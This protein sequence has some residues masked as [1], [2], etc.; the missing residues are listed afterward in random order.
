MARRRRSGLGSLGTFGISLGIGFAAVLVGAILP[1]PDG[2]IDKNV[3]ELTV[4]GEHLFVAQT[5]GTVKV[6]DA[7][8]GDHLY[9]ISGLDDIGDVVENPDGGLVYL[10]SGDGN[11]LTG[12][13]SNATIITADGDVHNAVIAKGHSGAAPIGGAIADGL[14]YTGFA[15]E[16]DTTAYGVS[17]TD[18]ET[19]ERVADYD[20]PAAPVGLDVRQGAI[21]V[22]L[23]DD[24]VLVLDADTGDVI[25]NADN[26]VAGE[27]VTS[28]TNL[29]VAGRV[30]DLA[31]LT[32]VYDDGPRGV[33]SYD[34][35]ADT[36]VALTSTH[37]H[38]L[39]A[40]K[41]TDSKRVGMPQGVALND[42]GTKAF[43]AAQGAIK[44]YKVTENGKFGAHV[45]TI[46]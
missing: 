9:N 24:S 7:N 35:A 45:D 10:R 41:Q 42:D 30:Y 5:N 21:Y 1:V 4:Q 14:V 38:A 32:Q 22:S 6:L 18:L 23:A 13:G 11:V 3:T 46:Q 19:L 40:N 20:L 36:V 15:V 39:Q 31:T 34:E 25:M 28:D 17:V 37:V 33:V 12:E 26:I 44:V 2:V 29:H 16:G 27:V 8:T 43:I